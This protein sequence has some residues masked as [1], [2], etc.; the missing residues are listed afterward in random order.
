MCHL[1]VSTTILLLP[2]LCTHIK[3]HPFLL[4][5]LAFG[6][7]TQISGIRSKVLFDVLF[8]VNMPQPFSC[9]IAIQRPIAR[10]L[11]IVHTPDSIGPAQFRPNVQ[12]FQLEPS[13]IGDRSTHEYNRQLKCRIPIPILSSL[14]IPVHAL[15]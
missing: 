15:V 7:G 1:T 13:M 2:T 14:E 8:L 6:I 11:G 5:I 10:I 4:H 9:N 3:A 12:P